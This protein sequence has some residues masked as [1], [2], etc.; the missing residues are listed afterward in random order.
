MSENKK[1]I[2]PCTQQ[3][4]SLLQDFIVPYEPFCVELCSHFK[5]GFEHFFLITTEET[6]TS[7]KQILGAFHFTRS[8]LFCIPDFFK[9]FPSKDDFHSLFSNFLSYFKERFIKVMVGQ[10]EVCNFFLEILASQNVQASQINHYKILT[11]QDE[12]FAPPEPLSC[13]DFIK[14]CTQ[15]DFDDLFPLQKNFLIKEVAL[16]NKQVTDSECSFMLTNMLKNQLVLALNTDSQL[17][18]KANTNAIGPHWVQLGGIYTLPL[19]RH[20]Y[21]AWHLIYSLSLRIQ[22]NNKSVCLFVKERN[23]PA[24]TLYQRIGFKNAGNFTIA[25]F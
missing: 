25:Y 11:L 1:Y 4:F 23:T 6:V 7:T 10:Q 9:T 3:N 22:N 14:C 5:Q 15:D 13:D 19:Y 2:I 20:N 17:V 12:P 18:A 16:K 24:Y 21:Y 8:F